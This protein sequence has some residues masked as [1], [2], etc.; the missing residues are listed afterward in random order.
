MPTAFEVPSQKLVEELALKLESDVPEISPPTWS[1]YVKTASFNQRPPAD[2]KWWYKRAASILHVVSMKGPIGISRLRSRYG[3]RKDLPM[4]KAHHAKS[5]S[6][7]IRRILSQLA[8][9]GLISSEKKGRVIT[10][11]G[12]SMLDSVA[13][14]IIKGGSS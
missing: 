11:K 4:R 7:A 1:Q 5:G 2:P 8:E 14:G 3:G 6:S 9:A 12:R 10:P 13:K